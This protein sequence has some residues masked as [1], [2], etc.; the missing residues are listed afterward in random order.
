MSPAGVFPRAALRQKQVLTSMLVMMAVMLS[1]IAVSIAQQDVATSE[2]TASLV[3]LA[4]RVPVGHAYRFEERSSSAINLRITARGQTADTQQTSKGTM[5]GTVAVLAVRGGMPSELRVDFEEDLGQTATS[6][7]QAQPMVLFPFSGRTVRVSIDEAGKLDLEAAD[8][9]GPLPAYSPQDLDTLKDLVVPDP[10]FPPVDP[11]GVGSKWTATLDQDE[12]GSELQMEFEVVRF[13]KIDG[14]RIAVLNATGTLDQQQSDNEFMAE[15]SGTVYVDLATGLPIR[16]ELSG[17]VTTRGV[18]TQDG[19]AFTIVGSG[20]ISQT[21]SQV[22]LLVTEQPATSR[23]T[24]ARG[25]EADAPPTVEGWSTFV[26]PTTG[27]QFQHPSSWRVRGEQRSLYIVPDDFDENTELVMAGVS[28]AD[29]ATKAS[30][31]SVAESISQ[32]MDYML[33]NNRQIGQPEPLETFRGDGAMYRYRGT[34]PDGRTAHVAALVCIDDGMALGFSV[35]ASQDLLERRLPTLRKMLATFHVPAR[36]PAMPGEGAQTDDRRLIGMFGGEAIA[37][38][39]D[40]GVYVN[41]R[42]V[43]ALGADGVLLYG[44]Q[45]A[46]TASDRDHTGELRWTASGQTAGNVQR[47][48]WSA[49]GGMLSVAWD[50]GGRSVFAYGF[51]PDGSLVLRDPRT[52]ELINFFERIR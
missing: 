48:R 27:I 25:A 47:G 20:T 41:T 52:R 24:E 51:E 34:L 13:T 4:Y 43:Y 42:L 33:P 22:P 50:G 36:K 5:R 45:S 17:P 32:V 23:T 6:F 16:S 14:V 40:A 35:F 3:R 12:P 8:D 19:Q 46:M 44:A 11:V 49:S 31:P 30:D 2:T 15:V 21:S 29:G 7:G 28:S 39:G 18:I 10:D 9:L 1:P 37:G 26:E 38:G